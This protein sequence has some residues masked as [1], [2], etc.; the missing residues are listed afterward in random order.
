M[1]GED[2]LPAREIGEEV[3][4]KLLPERCV[5]ALENIIEH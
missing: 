5:N 1:H 4:D 2:E 3:F